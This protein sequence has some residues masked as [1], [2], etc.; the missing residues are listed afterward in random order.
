MTGNLFSVDSFPGKLLDLIRDALPGVSKVGVLLNVSNP[1]NV[2]GWP[3]LEAAA[4]ATGVK[5]LPI[6]VRTPDDL[7]QGFKTAARDHVEFLLVFADVMFGAESRRIA[8]LALAARL[9]TLLRVRS[10]VVDGGLMSYGPDM[11]D[12]WRRTALYVDR[13]FERCEAGRT[14]AGVANQI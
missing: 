12:L 4:T 7:E 1:G 13:I 10:S 2:K 11:N 8:D 6:E 14:A 9:P 3:P 5:V